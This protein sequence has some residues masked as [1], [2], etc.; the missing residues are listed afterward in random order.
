M[1]SLSP[2][3]ADASASRPGDAPRSPVSVSPAP[4]VRPVNASN[5]FGWDYQREAA[6]FGPPVA[7]IIDIHSHVNGRRAAALLLRAC[8]LYGVQT[9]Y[10]M[11]MYE[12]ADVVREVFGD[13]IRFIA[14]PDYWAKENRRHALADGYIRRIEEWHAKGARVAKL[15]AAPRSIDTARELGDP[16]LFRLDAWFATKYADASIYGTKESQYDPFER[17]LDRFRST[18]F[19]AAHM[20]GTPENLAFLSALLDRHPNLVIDTSACKWQVR[21]WSKHRQ[22]EMLGFLLRYRTRILYGSDIVTTDDHLTSEGDKSNEMQRKAGSEQEAFDLYASRYWCY[23][24]MLETDYEGE[25]PVADPDLAMVE[26]DRF[27][28][29]SAPRLV[30]RALPPELLRQIYHDN[31]RRLF[32]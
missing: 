18:T 6:S 17:L 31:A 32:G 12:E 2:R 9:V 7:P 24:A 13:R 4:G 26:P 3:A 5:R 10:S 14:V 25:S 11:T 30:G 16:T 29:M 21:E 19:I 20:A 8:D 1:T 27:S 28:N 23:R 15:W 22:E